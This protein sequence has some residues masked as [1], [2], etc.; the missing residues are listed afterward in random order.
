MMTVNK[1]EFV[2]DMLLF[3]WATFVL[4]V[5]KVQ[6]MK[7][8]LLCKTVLF[9]LCTFHVAVSLY[10]FINETRC[11]Y[12]RVR[13]RACARVCVIY[14]LDLYNIYVHSQSLH[15]FCCRLLLF[16]ADSNYT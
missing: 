8:W 16:V 5:G 1:C 10:K 6:N 11:V 2:L 13:V 7:I 3:Y 15:S 14:A 12:V 9:I 4:L